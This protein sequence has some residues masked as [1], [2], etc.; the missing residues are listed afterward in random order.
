MVASNARKPGAHHGHRK[1]PA[2]TLNVYRCDHCDR[3]HFSAGLIAP[4]G[5][6][7]I[8]P[9][10]DSCSLPSA[11]NR[12]GVSL[13]LIVALFGAGAEALDGF[14]KEARERIIANAKR[15]AC[16]E[17]GGDGGH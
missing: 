13:D 6:G 10:A 7:L 16:G 9:P 14:P 8:H 1:S 5:G 2:L 11:L 4:D 12:A 3:W 17:D 15:N